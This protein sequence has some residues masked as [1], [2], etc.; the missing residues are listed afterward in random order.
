MLLIRVVGKP[1]MLT[2]ENLETIG[3]G[4]QMLDEPLILDIV[5]E[6]CKKVKGSLEGKPPT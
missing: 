3:N 1:L 6:L 4:H 2:L 5:E